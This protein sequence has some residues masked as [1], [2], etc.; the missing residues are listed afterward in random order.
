MTMVPTLVASSIGAGW[1]PQR[2]SLSD[3]AHTDPSMVS[4]DCFL[5][6]EI[7]WTPGSISPQ[8]LF[9]RE[10]YNSTLILSQTIRHID[11]GARLELYI[12]INTR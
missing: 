1:A 9:G 7:S 12:M 11:D 10:K 8:P 2:G 3:P 6:F 5:S 4:P